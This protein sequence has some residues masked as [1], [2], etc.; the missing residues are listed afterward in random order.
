MST[1]VMN[2]NVNGNFR[3]PEQLAAEISPQNITNKNAV[4][5]VTEDPF[6]PTQVNRENVNGVCSP[7]MS[8][9]E[10]PEADINWPKL[11]TL[12]VYDE[13]GNKIKF[14]DI[15]R[16]QK[17]LVIFVR[18]ICTR[19]LGVSQF[20]YFR[21]SSTYIDQAARFHWLSVFIQETDIV[22]LHY[23][24]VSD[25]IRFASVNN[26]GGHHVALCDCAQ[27][28]LWLAVA[29]LG[30]QLCRGKHEFNDGRMKLGVYPMN[31]PVKLILPWT[32][33]NHLHPQI[34][35]CNPHLETNQAIPY[36]ESIGCVIDVL[37]GLIIDGHVCS[38]HCHICARGG[39]F[40]REETPQRYQCWR[41][42]HIASGECTINFEGSS[43]MMELKA[44]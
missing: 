29:V 22:F 17:T 5:Q 16:R 10:R 35:H 24:L 1:T 42:Q 15:Y 41:Q 12:Y 6:A 30:S 7:N 25:L 14:S 32:N 43:G 11:E 26:P 40:V 27:R 4:K 20:L 33:H 44:A 23:D 19:F 13:M 34:N 3:V 37:T 31:Q 36:K 9:G 8:R 21:R 28:R 2:P 38:L 39:E 18:R